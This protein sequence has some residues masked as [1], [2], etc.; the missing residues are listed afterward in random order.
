MF[1]KAHD[2]GAINQKR[3]PSEW[4]PAHSSTGVSHLLITG[5]GGL[6]APRMDAAYPKERSKAKGQSTQDPTAWP[7]GIFMNLLKLHSSVFPNFM[8]V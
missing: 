2:R 4:M 5:W 7:L 8:C 1:N 6:P 3:Y